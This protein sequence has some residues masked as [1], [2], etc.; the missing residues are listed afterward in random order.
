MTDE[1]PVDPDE[2]DLPDEFLEYRGPLRDRPLRI[3]GVDRESGER[4][5]RAVT[6]EDVARG[7]ADRRRIDADD[8]S[9]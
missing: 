2:D 5:D 9:P 4:F 6:I 7:F 8:D 1:L 3:S